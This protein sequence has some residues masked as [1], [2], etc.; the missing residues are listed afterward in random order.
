MTD[1]EKKTVR[2]WKCTA[3]KHEW[4]SKQNPPKVCPGCHK[5]LYIKERRQEPCQSME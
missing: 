4:P 1:N 2:I 3:C 5:Y